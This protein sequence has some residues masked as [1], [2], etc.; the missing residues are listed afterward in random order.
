[1]AERIRQDIAFYLTFEEIVGRL[2]RVK[3]RGAFETRHL[4]RRKI[5]HADST[6][7]TLLVEPTKCGGRLFNGDE[8]IGPMQLIDI[9]VVGLQTVERILEFPENTLAC[10]VPLDSAAGPV[11]AK[12][13]C[14]DNTLSAAIL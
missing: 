3:W 13:G 7:L 8:R 14:Q 5:A 2:N 10:R 9:D 6:N 12:F 4:F 1:M 11:D